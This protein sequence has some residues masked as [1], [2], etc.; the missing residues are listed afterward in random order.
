M[1]DLTKNEKLNMENQV[2]LNTK[3][4]NSEDDVDTWCVGIYPWL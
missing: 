2:R 1:I 3:K 4:F